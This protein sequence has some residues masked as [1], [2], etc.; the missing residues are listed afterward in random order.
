MTLI[1]APERIAAVLGP[2]HP[3][4]DEAVQRLHQYTRVLDRWARGQ[5]LVGWRRAEALLH[6]GI[7]DAWSAVPLLAD[8]DA[9]VVDVGSG[10][11]L[12]AL[13]F[14]A[15]LPSRTIH[16]IEARRKRASFLKEAAR[17]MGVSAVVVHHGRTDDLRAEG[18]FDPEGAL[19]TSRAFAAPI[20]VLDL[21]T[22]WGASRCLVTSSNP[23]IP[24]GDPDGWSTE[25][26]IESRPHGDSSHVLYRRS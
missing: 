12:P 23:K 20:E 6:D 13:V 7:R 15:G 4:H 10:A 24:G 21:A 9:P 19:I 26:R 22:S 25:V 2:V 18:A 14:A 11:G 5:R 16:L 17:L 1:C 3:I 8:V